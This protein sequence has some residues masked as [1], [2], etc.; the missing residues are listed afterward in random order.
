VSTATVNMLASACAE[1]GD[2]ARTLSVINHEYS[3]YGVEIN[4]DTFGFGFESM[5]KLVVKGKRRKFYDEALKTNIMDNADR[6][7]FM[8]G[9]KNLALTDHIVRE[10]V[11]L[12]CAIGEVE[13]ATDVILDCL[14]GGDPVNQKTLYRAATANL[15][16]HR[17]DA[18][19]LLAD[20]SVQPM[21]YLLESIEKKEARFFERQLEADAAAGIEMSD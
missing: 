2:M 21:P 19:R 14:S 17:F 20:K 7:L 4:A 9:D 1:R 10:Y 3:R 18:A 12:L 15:Q 8:L 5:G 13:T 11:E 6:L 16:V